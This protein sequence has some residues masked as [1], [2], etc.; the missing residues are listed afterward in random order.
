ME[1]G[2]ELI[3][4]TVKDLAALL[5]HH[6]VAFVSKSLQCFATLADKHQRR[7]VDPKDLLG[8]NLIERLL[9]LLVR[10]KPGPTADGAPN[11]DAPTG[12]TIVSLL[13]GLW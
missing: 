6:V 5:D 1:P 4:E 10:S 3:P 2:D 11:V 12:R 9:R 8:D 7:S 13:G